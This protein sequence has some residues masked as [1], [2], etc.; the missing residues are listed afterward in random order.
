MDRAFR[1]PREDMVATVRETLQAAAHP[2]LQKGVRCISFAA[3]KPLYLELRPT[4]R[5][6]VTFTV[7]PQVASLKRKDQVRLT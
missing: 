6:T 4:P 2:E 3:C 5:I 7:P 1:L